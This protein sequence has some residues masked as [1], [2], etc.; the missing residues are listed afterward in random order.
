M[1]S[2]ERVELALNHK[3]PDKVPF[4]IGGTP[5]SG[6]A[7]V[8][9][10]NLLNYL[11]KPE[12]EI[13]MY[14]H[15]QQLAQVDKDILDYLKIDTRIVTPR[16]TQAWNLKI[17]EDGEYYHFTDEWGILWKM[18]KVKGFYF[19]MVKRPLEDID[20]V[21]DLKGY[22]WPDPTDTARY[23][24]LREELEEVY[25]K[26]GCA[27]VMQ[28][29]CAGLFELAGWLRGFENFFVDLMLNPELAC[30]I[31]DKTMEIK[32]AYWDKVLS[33]GG[34]YISV[35]Q[36][37]DDLGTQDSLL[38]SK[39]LY[40]KYVKPRHIE[41]NSFIKKKAPHA[42]IFYHSCGAIKELIPDLIESGV[43]IL[44]PVQ[45]SAKGMGDTKAL[46]KEFGKDI[47]FWGGGV[48]T[49]RILPK[50]TPQE[51]KDEVKRRLEDLMP[52]G[53][54]VFNT[55]HNIQADVPPQNIMA[56]WE[57]LQEYGVYK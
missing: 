4:D 9:Y 56:M 11:G 52:Y 13:K 8:A 5:V 19:D 7:K 41:L 38:L 45:V 21:D 10:V 30:A 31:M 51:V 3:E 12:R 17:D 57:A 40:R 1:N 6:I 29:M 18:P 39:E 2:R 47:I 55:V 49:Q 37:A 48:D 46:K 22:K 53:G 34:E 14:D 33:N 20:S 32:M 16:T 15:I 23:T 42:K 35:I 28:C 36:E 44:N 25:N 50:G 27:I 43:E 26:S 54:F 24:G